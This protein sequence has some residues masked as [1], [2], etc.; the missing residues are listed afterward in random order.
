MKIHIHCL[1]KNEGLLLGQVLRYWQ[2]YPVEKFIFFDDCSTDDT[3]EKINQFLGR[4]AIIIS[5]KNTPFNEALFRGKMFEAS[6]MHRPAPT[7]ILAIDA[8]ELVTSNFFGHAHSLADLASTNRV[9]LHWYNSAGNMS[10]YRADR[11]YAMA[12]VPCFADIKNVGPFNLHM[13]NYHLCPRIPHRTMPPAYVK[14]VGIIHLQ[15]LNKRFY[16]LKQLWYKHYEYINYNN[17][18]ME[19]NL[20]YDKMVNNGDFNPVAFDRKLIE[21]IEIDD[22]FPELEL[23]KG[24]LKYIKK[25]LVQELVTFGGEYLQ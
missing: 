20:K 1:V 22:I 7:H 14:D 24:Y 3:C 8:D 2:R 9:L 10:S 6:L 17:P 19:I 5:N 4:K 16:I 15:S 23:Q 18:I 11:E 12:T 21:G 25:N 13:A